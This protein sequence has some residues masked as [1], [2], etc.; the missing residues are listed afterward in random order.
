MYLYLQH[1]YVQEGKYRV[2]IWQKYD[3]KKFYG[4]SI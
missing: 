3:L 4:K 1:T 2:E